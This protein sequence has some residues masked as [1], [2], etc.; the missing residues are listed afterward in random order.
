MILWQS[1]PREQTTGATLRH[2][3]TSTTESTFYAFTLV[4]H[5][6]QDYY[7]DYYSFPVPLIIATNGRRVNLRFKFADL[8]ATEPQQRRSITLVTNIKLLPTTLVV[9]GQHSVRCVRVRTITFEPKWPLIETLGKP[10][11]LDP[12]WVQLFVRGAMIVIRSR[13]EKC[14]LF[15]GYSLDRKVKD[16]KAV[17]ARCEQNAGGNDT[18]PIS[19]SVAWRKYTLCRILLL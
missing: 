16:G 8:D 12:I 14:S 5:S 19:V 18:V 3:N 7:S 11:H 10:V 13:D 4:A 1:L 15:F 2:A 9:Q 17:T 6:K